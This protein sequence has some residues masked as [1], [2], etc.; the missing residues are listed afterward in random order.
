MEENEKETTE[1]TKCR[2]CKNFIPNDAI[3]CS[4]CNRY[5]ST[6]KQFIRAEWIGLLISIIM[7]MI[8]LKQLNQAN[9]ERDKASDAL[10]KANIALESVKDIKKTTIKI[11]KE[12]D[13]IFKISD[14]ARNKAS[15]LEKVVGDAIKLT[16][17][18]KEKL[19]NLEKESRIE[20]LKTRKKMYEE[21]RSST[22]R[23]VERLD[24]NWN[25]G[26]M[27][28]MR[29]M[30]HVINIKQQKNHFNRE[31]RLLEEQIKKLETELE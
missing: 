18:T 5:Q 1:K 14:S 19:I 13:E 7:L 30:Q 12:S 29:D 10:K 8:A 16:S 28:D 15:E 17:K 31:I 2:Y 27:K 22:S 3:V 11:Q 4:H 9:E 20:V 6:Y 23:T 26:S 24:R 21:L 25:P